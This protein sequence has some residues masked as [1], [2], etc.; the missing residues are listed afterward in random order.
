VHADRPAVSNHITPK[1][2]AFAHVTLP[3][4][5]RHAIAF[6]WRDGFALSR[7][8]KEGLGILGARLVY[9]G[10]VERN[11]NAFSELLK[12]IGAA[13]TFSGGVFY[14][15][16]SLTAS[17]ERL[18]RAV[19]LFADMLAKPAM[20][21][22]T[23][24]F[25]KNNAAATAQQVSENAEGL[26]RR[27]MDR[28]T[29]G[30]G[31]LLNALSQPAE[32]FLD[33]TIE[34]VEA[35]RK[36]VLVRDSVIVASAGPMPPAAVAVE[37][38]RLFAGL[39]LHVDEL[40]PAPRPAM[41]ASG[42]VIVLERAVA[43]TVIVASGPSG[44]TTG[45]DQLRADLAIQSM[46]G[47]EGRIFRALRERLGASYGVQAFLRHFHDSAKAM[48]IV[49]SVD[50]KKASDAISAIRS[51]YSRLRTDGLTDAEIAPLKNKQVASMD[52]TA[53]P[54]V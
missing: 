23:F 13:T 14:T 29:I 16:G 52:D 12:D 38:D 39:P 45:P 8:G 18:G 10:T 6:G 28:L 32:T 19:A 43:Q 24:T 34:D 27:L 15:V 7:P 54:N 4:E 44:W 22:G 31:P 49:S 33:V 17:P 30:A 41:R 1:G 5:P 9:E 25:L 53:P 48:M 11:R 21:A 47:F 35:W 46:V 3:D 36:A 42:K 2:I 40:P 51:E 50:S 37:I 26:A 20:F